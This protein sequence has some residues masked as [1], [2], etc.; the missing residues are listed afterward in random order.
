MDYV[1]NVLCV[2]RLVTD[3]YTSYNREYCLDFVP[4]EGTGYGPLTAEVYGVSHAFVV[5]RVDQLLEVWA[6]NRVS[7]FDVT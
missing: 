3:D 4:E 5:V 7:V 6:C 1:N 2:A